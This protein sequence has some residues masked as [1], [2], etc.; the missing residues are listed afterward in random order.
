MARHDRQPDAVREAERVDGVGGSE[1][2]EVVHRGVCPPAGGRG[3]VALD[4]MHGDSVHLGQDEGR[5]RGDRVGEVSQRID[6]DDAEALG[7]GVLQQ[8]N[9]E[10]TLP[11]RLEQTRRLDRRVVCDRKLVGL[12]R[13]RD[14]RRAGLTLAASKLRLIARQKCVFLPKIARKKDMHDCSKSLKRSTVTWA[15]EAFWFRGLSADCFRYVRGLF[16]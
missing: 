13:A 12:R 11:P 7:P 5:V 10:L 1:V 2:E 15:Y 6:E 14:E 16:I 4:L 8:A 9:E 3:R